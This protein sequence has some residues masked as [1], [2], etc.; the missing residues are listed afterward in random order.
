[1]KEQLKGISLIGTITA[2]AFQAILIQKFTDTFNRTPCRWVTYTKISS[3][4]EVSVVM[5]IPHCPSDLS[6]SIHSV[7]GK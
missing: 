2:Y 5:L 7:H 6:H 1:M 4:N 3:E